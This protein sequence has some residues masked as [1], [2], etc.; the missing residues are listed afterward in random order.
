MKSVAFVYQDHKPFYD[1]GG[2]YGLT[3]DRLCKHLDDAEQNKLLN[4]KDFRNYARA[5]RL[6]KDAK[7]LTDVPGYEIFQHIDFQRFGSIPTEE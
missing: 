7:R 2:V 3:A 6:K 4:D 5:N 1:T